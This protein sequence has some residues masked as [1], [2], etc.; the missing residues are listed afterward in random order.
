MKLAR[1][2]LRDPKKPIANLVF[3]GPTGVGKTELTKK[4]AEELNLKL[5]RFDMSEYNEKHTLSRLI[6]APPGYVGHEA[7]GLLTE[8]VYKSPH[9]IV[10]LDEIE[11]AHPDIYPVLLQVMD[12]GTLT[13][14]NGRKVDFRHVT[15]IMTTNAGAGVYDKGGYGFTHK[16]D[17]GDFNAEIKKLFSPEFRNRLDGVIHFKPLSLTHI[18]KIVVKELNSLSKRLASKNVQLEYHENLVIW[19]ADKGYDA[20]MGARP[21]ERTV[22]EEVACRLSDELLFG[23]VSS[24][25]KVYFCIENNEVAM[26]SFSKEE[27][28]KCYLP[29]N[30]QSNVSS[31]LS[32][33]Q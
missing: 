24:G 11:K 28:K 25:G 18:K 12:H 14:G 6:G 9:S 30:D 33:I 20:K 3:A 17:H 7:G 29:M 21:I 5:I 32:Q 15:L 22:K 8:E 1:S 4:L 19:L 27:L 2:G 16:A 26:R 31:H 13:D 10:L 23:D